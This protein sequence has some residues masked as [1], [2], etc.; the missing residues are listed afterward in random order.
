MHTPDCIPAC[1]L[2]MPDRASLHLQRSQR[3]KEWGHPGC[4]HRYEGVHTGS[5]CFHSQLGL[6]RDYQ[7]LPETTQGLTQRLPES[8]S[9]H[10]DTT[11]TPRIPIICALSPTSLSHSPQPN[12]RRPQQNIKI[13]IRSLAQ[14]L[15]IPSVADCSLGSHRLP[16]LGVGWVAVRICLSLRCHSLPSWV[17][18]PRIQHSRTICMTFGIKI[19]ISVPEAC[20]LITITLF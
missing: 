12:H 11:T 18:T 15:G 13:F 5:V 8:A 20:F 9:K 6:A 17:K 3:S 4:I 7:R 1:W 19:S 2:A 10:R 14:H 16:I